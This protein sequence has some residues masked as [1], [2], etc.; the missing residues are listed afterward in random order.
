[1]K[2]RWKRGTLPFKT[3]LRSSRYDFRFLRYRRVK[4]IVIFNRLLLLSSLVR[5]SRLH[6]YSYRLI[7]SLKQVE[8]AIRSK[9]FPG[10]DMGHRIVGPFLIFTTVLHCDGYISVTDRGTR[11]NQNV[12]SVA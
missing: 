6:A 9:L 11:M 12:T 7:S 8:D 2:D 4:E 5:N 1:M 10:K 3:V